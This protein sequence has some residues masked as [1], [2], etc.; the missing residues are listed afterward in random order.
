MVRE[1]GILV[2]IFVTSNET[3]METI[4]KLMLRIFEANAVEFLIVYVG[5]KSAIERNH[6][7][8]YLANLSVGYV[9]K[10][11]TG[12]IGRPALCNFVRP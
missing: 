10:A 6:L 2:N 1:T 12:R 9:K 3:S 7:V 4:G 8:R 5:V 11:T